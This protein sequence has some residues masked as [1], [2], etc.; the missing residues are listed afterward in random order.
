V[1]LDISAGPRNDDVGFYPVPRLL[2]GF[3]MSSYFSTNAISDKA[4]Q[5]G[6]T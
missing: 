3:Q 6:L 1:K 4:E 5:L 2:V